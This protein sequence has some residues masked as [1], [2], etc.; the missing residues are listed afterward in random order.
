MQTLYVL[1]HGGD[2]DRVAVGALVI[3][4]FHVQHGGRADTGGRDRGGEYKQRDTDNHG[5]FQQGRDHDQGAYRNDRDDGADDGQ[6]HPPLVFFVFLHQIH[7][8]FLRFLLIVGV[9]DPLAGEKVVDGDVQR[10]AQGEHQAD[11]GQSLAPFPFGY[12]FVADAEFVCQLPL[13]QALDFSG[14]GD[15]SADLNLVHG[16]PPF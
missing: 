10:S 12:G 15:K 5:H 6:N 14:R 3:P 8:V 7:Y 1:R 9:A 13:G 2:K 16:A 4:G 11:L